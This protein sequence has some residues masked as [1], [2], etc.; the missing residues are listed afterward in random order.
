M[1][2]N[3]CRNFP[4]WCLSELS[5]LSALQ[6]KLDYEVCHQ[7]ER[8]NKLFEMYPFLVSLA[9]CLATWKKLARW[10]W[11]NAKS[12]GEKTD[13]GEIIVLLHGVC[14]VLWGVECWHNG[15]LHSLDGCGERDCCVLRILI[16]QFLWERNTVSR[17]EKYSWQ[18]ERNTNYMHQTK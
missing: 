8:G 12:R 4:L 9:M 7:T 16:E 5:Q 17:W 11:E 2:Y 6:V 18:N 14:W 10:K 13:N 1:K 15:L 3:C